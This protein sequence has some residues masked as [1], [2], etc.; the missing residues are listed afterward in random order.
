[1]NLQSLWK[2]LENEAASLG[3]VG[4]LRRRVVPE[5]TPDLFVAVQ[6]V[7]SQIRMFIV[8]IGLGSAPQKNKLPE[9]K[10]CELTL[11]KFSDDPADKLSLCL[12]LLD[13]RYADV[14]ASFVADVVE[15]LRQLA[16]DAAVVAALISRIERWKSFLDRAI[17]ECLVAEEQRGLY[18]ELW[19]LKNQLLP[20][21]GL[22]AAVAAWTGPLSLPHDFQTPAYS[23]EVKAT[24]S[25]QH[26][27]IAISN[28][29]QLDDAH[30]EKLLL[31]HLSLET[32]A[33]GETLPDLVR[34]IQNLVRG[35]VM[36]H[37]F[38]ELLAQG[39]YS[40]PHIDHYEEIHYQKRETHLFRVREGFPRLVETD[41]PAGVGDL[42][43]SVALASCL[44]F[45]VDAAHWSGLLRGESNG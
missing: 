16:S 42:R 37:R 23:V 30:V 14:F 25:K 7:P 38:E 24:V 22:D 32:G 13:K 31:F 43:Y 34:D 11:T 5:A 29:R 10:G 45:S 12:C 27:R 33:A 39:G 3:R 15:H 8:R 2:E 41:L 36:E 26:T 19:F 20:V 21:I 9:A 6:Q 35:T 18:G 17:G 40:A 28:E 4:V 44:P 1:M